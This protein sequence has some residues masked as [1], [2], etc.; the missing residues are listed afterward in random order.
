MSPRARGPFFAQGPNC[1]STRVLSLR[2]A[3]LP[4]V[5]WLWPNMVFLLRRALAGSD[6]LPSSAPRHG[7]GRPEPAGHWAA[8]LAGCRARWA[9]PS[10]LPRNTSTSQRP[11]GGPRW[12]KPL[13]E[14]F[15][16]KK[17]FPLERG[18]RNELRIDLR[19]EQKIRAKNGPPWAAWRPAGRSSGRRHLESNKFATFFYF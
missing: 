10:S 7:A 4:P 1:R 13:Q 15:W 17:R 18:K 14:T 12:R 5:G 2:V 19:S 9:Q 6:G 8:S 3:A 11:P 16:S